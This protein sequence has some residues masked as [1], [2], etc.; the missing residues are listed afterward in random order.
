MDFAILFLVK[1]IIILN[2]YPILIVIPMKKIILSILISFS[3]FSGLTAQ[4]YNEIKDLNMGE[5]L[6]TQNSEYC[7]IISPDSRYIV[8]QSDRPGGEGGM[9]IWIAENKNYRDRLGKPEWTEP[10]NFRELN[11]PS[12]EGGFSIL[13]DEKNEPKEIFFTSVSDS[14]SKRDG[15]EGTNIYHTK[16]NHNTNKWS[17]PVHINEI[18]SDFDDKMP[19]ITQN[20]KTLIFSSNRTGGFGG[21]DLWVSHRVKDKVKGDTWTKPK[22]LGSKV[23][24]KANEI[25]AYMHYDGMTLFFSSDRENPTFKYSIFRSNLEVNLDKVKGNETTYHFKQLTLTDAQLLGYP[26][27]S[28]YD[29]EG[30]SISKDG[31]WIYFSSNRSGGEGQFDIYRT[32]MPE[33]LR[34]PYPF[35]FH[36]L[37]LDGSEKKMIGVDATIKIKNEKGL[38]KVITSKRIGGD[39]SL[40]ADINNFETKLLTGSYYRI[41]ISSPGFE[42]TE[43]GLDL[44]GN[45]GQ[46]KSKYIRVVLMPLKEEVEK[47]KNGDSTK[48]TEENTDKD[49]KKPIKDQKSS[50]VRIFIRDFKTKKD[51]SNAKL[52]LFTEKDRQGI[53]INH[54][55]SIFV[56]QEIPK[57][58]FEIAASAKGY[59]DETLMLKKNSEE[60]KNRLDIII[61]LKKNKDYDKI[62]NEVIYFQ[63]NEHLITTEQQKKLDILAEYLKKNLDTIE[64]GGH[65]DNIASKEYNVQLSERRSI[66]VKKYLEKK[67][68]DSKRVIAKAYWYSQPAFDNSTEDGRA[69]NRRV[70]FKKIDK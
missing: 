50:G 65:T 41:E 2:S 62:F 34:R 15:F 61:Y 8:F 60:I 19:A 58:D 46:N 18:N 45:I 70:H 9:D 7:P 43:L 3:L 1:I 53:S 4:T 26:F 29:N 64:I 36:G 59:K 13:F 54:T 6:N 5:P 31:L 14:K 11:T 27:N 63:F 38:V 24:S 66:E 44:R 20:G 35:L 57:E 47:P 30:L 25:M 55:K 22:N 42:P 21:L 68:I 51:I 49:V 23:N 69:K 67:G 32:Q 33:E 52:T 39:L 17:K 40:D 10:V 37:V 12:F 28:R 48:K 56:I 16:F